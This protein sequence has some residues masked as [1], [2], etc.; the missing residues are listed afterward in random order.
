[1]K[2][3]IKTLT[4]KVRGKKKPT[5]ES[6]LRKRLRFLEDLEKKIKLDM[7]TAKPSEL[8][9]LREEHECLKT[10]IAEFSAILGR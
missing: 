6:R 5:I 4:K 8:A 9:E 1:M 2:S 3:P 7:E 10:V